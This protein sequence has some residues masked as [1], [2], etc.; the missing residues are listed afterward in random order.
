M[1]E[2][3]AFNSPE[4]VVQRT[5]Q[6]RTFKLV[7]NSS[8]SSKIFATVQIRI[9]NPTTMSTRKL[10]TT[11]IGFTAN[12]MDMVAIVTSLAGISRVNKNK[13]YT[14]FNRFVDQELSQLKE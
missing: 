12:G 6:S 4:M 13:M 10:F 8:K 3:G 5:R 7:Y 14:M 9:A 1:C 11:P 2:D